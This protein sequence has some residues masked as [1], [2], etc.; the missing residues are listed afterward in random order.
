MVFA[1][2]RFARADKRGKLPRWIQEHLPESHLNLTVDEAVQA[3]KRFL[4][5]MAQPF[6]QEDQ[7]G[8]S[9]LTWEQLQAGEVLQRIQGISQQA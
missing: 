9:L 8:L 3:A 4:R 7:L 1:D 6:R 2:K 5:E